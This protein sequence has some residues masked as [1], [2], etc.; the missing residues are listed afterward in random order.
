METEDDPQMIANTKRI[1]KQYPK[2][3]QS[4]RSINHI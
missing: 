2:N 4:K 1:Q 3:T